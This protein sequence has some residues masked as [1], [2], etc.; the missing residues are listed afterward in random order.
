MM[1]KL[2]RT[3]EDPFF[4]ANDDSWRDLL[5]KGMRASADNIFSYDLAYYDRLSCRKD[6]KEYQRDHTLCLPR[7]VCLPY[8][9][10]YHT[11]TSSGHAQ[12]LA[13]QEVLA[14]AAVICLRLPTQ[15][16]QQD[17]RRLLQR[18][19]ASWGMP[20]MAHC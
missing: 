11:L 12:V 13:T 16:L 18:A 10:V 20:L 6:S 7:K 19:G 3:C 4:K 1:D 15:A 17:N 5:L 8:T 9:D 14:W 2:R